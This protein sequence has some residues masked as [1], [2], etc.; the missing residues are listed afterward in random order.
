MAA[1]RV[2]RRAIARNVPLLTDTHEVSVETVG[3][4]GVHAEHVLPWLETAGGDVPLAI[5]REG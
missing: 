4:D 3:H 1:P 5:E 2:D